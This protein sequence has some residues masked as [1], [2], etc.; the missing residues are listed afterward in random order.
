MAATLIIPALRGDLDADGV[1][2]ILVRDSATGGITMLTM[3]GLDVLAETPLFDGENVGPWKIAAVTDLNS[4]GY[5]DVVFESEG[6]HTVTF[7][8]A[9]G[10][11]TGV[12]LF[13]E[14]ESIAPWK[15]VAGGDMN[16]DGNGDL[17]LQ[18]DNSGAYAVA[19]MDGTNVLDA[20]YLFDGADIA[21]WHVVAAGDVNGDTLTDLIIRHSED[22]TYGA[23]IMDNLQLLDAD[24]F[25]ANGSTDW[26]PWSL[27]AVSDLNGDGKSDL[28][29]DDPASGAKFAVFLD[30]FEGTEGGYLNGDAAASPAGTVVG[31]R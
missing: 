12:Y 25:Y 3:N 20:E 18:Y 15:V 4:D 13:G 8:T 26:N 27:A 5:E 23:A 17:I 22:S 16:A 14:A 6:V 11:T 29:L 19:Y 2:D 28:I 1:G 9:A 31:P 24:Y 7:M 21:P 10:P 30:G